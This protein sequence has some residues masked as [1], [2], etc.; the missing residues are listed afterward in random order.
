MWS[1]VVLSPK[2]TFLAA[3]TY[4]APE[5][6]SQGHIIFGGGEPTHGQFYWDIYATGSG[7]KVASGN[8]AFNDI[9]PSVI[10]GTAQWIAESYLLLPQD[11]TA[12]HCLLIAT[13]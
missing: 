3:L 9:S 6:P 2:Q 7:E 12:Q 4:T 10:A 8:F 11:N 13:Q 5:K 1:K